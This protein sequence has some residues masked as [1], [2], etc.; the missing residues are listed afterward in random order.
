[1]TGATIRR[2]T[3]LTLLLCFVAV[4]LTGCGT[5]GFTVTDP[6][7][8]QIV[9]QHVLIYVYVS[10][11][12]FVEVDNENTGRLGG[13]D[14]E[15]DIWDPSAASYVVQFRGHVAAEVTHDFAC[16]CKVGDKVQVR[17]DKIVNG[18][19]A[20]FYTQVTL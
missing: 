15:F 13:I 1:M 6:I 7:S 16:K 18:K 5:S 8:P 4:G 12:N 2:W 10:P 3:V 14:I 19:D 11:Q 20:T 17:L 9:W